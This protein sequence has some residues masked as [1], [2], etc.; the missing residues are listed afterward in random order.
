VI[1]IEKTITDAANQALLEMKSFNDQSMSS[2]EDFLSRYY[3]LQGY[4]HLALIADSGLSTEA[5]DKLIEIEQQ[6][7]QVLNSE[8]PRSRILK[9]GV[10]MPP[11]H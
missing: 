2:R 3:V 6:S 8:L 4:I 10:C 11:S 9:G 7:I 1:K 5:V